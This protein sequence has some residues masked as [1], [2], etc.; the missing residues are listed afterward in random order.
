MHIFQ[1]R[2]PRISHTQKPCKRY[3]NT[4]AFRILEVVLPRILICSI[5]LTLIF[6]TPI[7]IY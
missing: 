2:D 4:S 5:F 1:H 3:T 6:V 7:E